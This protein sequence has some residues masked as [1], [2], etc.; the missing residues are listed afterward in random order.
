[1]IKAWA[2]VVD[3]QILTDT[4]YSTKLGAETNYVNGTRDPNDLKTGKAIAMRV[5]I[6]LA[7]E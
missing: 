2:M 7:T 4:V 3:N 1:M 5:L 6:T